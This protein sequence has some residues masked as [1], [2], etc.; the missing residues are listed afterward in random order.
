MRFSSR[1]EMAAG[2]VGFVGRTVMDNY[3]F[4]TTP[5]GCWG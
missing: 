3:R 2:D 4:D 1:L 5:V